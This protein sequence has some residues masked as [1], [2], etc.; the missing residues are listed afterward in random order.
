MNRKH[1]NIL[2]G[3]A[4]LLMPFSLLT[5]PGQGWAH[6]VAFTGSTSIMFESDPKRQDAM[7]FYSHR[8]WLATG[9]TYSRLSLEGEVGPLE[10]NIVTPQINLLAHRWNRP[11][12]Q[13]N[14]YFSGG[15]GTLQADGERN[16]RLVT[17]SRAGVQ[18]DA[19]TRRLYT[20]FK[21]EKL[22]LDHFPDIDSYVARGGLA[23]FLGNF[24]DLNIWFILEAKYA[25]QISK[26][27]SFTPLLRF[28]LKNVLWEVGSSLKGESYL[29]F[30]VH[31]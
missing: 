16:D 4:V 21:Y 11:D 24:D 27:P 30:M 5:A 25:A 1:C 8:Y 31:L 19:E 29:S 22:T 20:L 13:A 23:P 9:I 26:Q 18:F 2:S 28:Y 14:L 3:L 17:A 6:P 10:L 7:L 15:Y 12:S